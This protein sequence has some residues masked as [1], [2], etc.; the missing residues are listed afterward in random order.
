MFERST[1]ALIDIQSESQFHGELPSCQAEGQVVSCRKGLSMD[2]LTLTV[3]LTAEE[4]DFQA[5]MA[6][7]Q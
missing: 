3:K 2:K 6:S 7:L 1:L 4:T 5:T